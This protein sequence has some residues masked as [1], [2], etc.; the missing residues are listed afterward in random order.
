MKEFTVKWLSSKQPRKQRKYRYNAPTHLRR[1]MLSSHLSKTLRQEYKKRSLPIRK[2]DEVIIVR[3]AFR[4]TTGKVTRVDL[5][6]LKIYVDNAK[7]KKVSGQDIEV[8]ID[9]S[10]VI[11]TRLSLEDRKRKKFILR[12][13]AKTDKKKET[14]KTETKEKK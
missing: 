9:P 2:D 13:E 14:A 6:A 3:G 5:K 7:R 10:N 8:P 4:K 11:I 12:K 1:K